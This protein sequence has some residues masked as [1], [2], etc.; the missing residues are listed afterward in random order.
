ME[1]YFLRLCRMYSGKEKNAVEGE[2]GQ[3]LP[4]G[5]TRVLSVFQLRSGGGAGS[6]NFLGPQFT[7]VYLELELAA[8]SCNQSTK[9]K[10]LQSFLSY[11]L[12]C[13]VFTT[14]LACRSG[15]Q[16]LI[17]VLR[18]RGWK[19]FLV[20][21]ADV[22]ANFLLVKAYQYT[23]LT[24]IQLLDCFTIAMVL[25]L[26]WLFLKVRYKIVHILGVGVAL[27]GVGCL[28]WADLEE[29]KISARNRFLGD[30]LC[31]TGAALYGVSN[32]AE[33]FVIKTY[34]R[35]E[36]LG[37]LGLFGSVLNGIQLAI[38][39]RAELAVINWEEWEEVSFLLGYTMCLFFLYVALPI[40]MKNT[41]ATAVNLSILTADFYSLLIGSYIFNNQFH[42]LYV[43]SFFL[44]LTGV[45][46]YSLQPTPM[47]TAHYREIS[48]AELQ[49]DLEL[50]NQTPCSTNTY[51]SIGSARNSPG[52][53]HIEDSERTKGMTVVSISHAVSVHAADEEDS[54]VKRNGNAKYSHDSMC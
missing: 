33:E 41:S 23:T 2:R 22:E 1:G 28:V 46:V 53:E 11:V 26:S 34:N 47:G 4:E 3:E 24:S 44:F 18:S 13:T 51:N 36:F 27:L 30:M 9:F 52:F 7:M 31:L 29:E 45:L 19:Y 38:L 14:W 35:V 39:E 42:W 10:H 40:V 5:L 12:L 21:V 54:G 17:P 20:A 8:C 37:M 48:V 6:S 15:D 49:G 25:A 16:G 32:V 50:A 43:L